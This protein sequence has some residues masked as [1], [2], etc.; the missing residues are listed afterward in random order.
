MKIEQYD[1]GSI[2]VD[3]KAYTAD[4]ILF[5]DRV[6]DGW[7]REQG[8]SLSLDDVDSVLGVSPEYLVIGTG[9]YGLMKIPPEVSRAIASKGIELCVSATVEACRKYN[10]LVSRG[11][12]VV[13]AFHLTC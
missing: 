10:E 13:G 3:G 9:R 5:P 6:Q 4:I 8:H 11:N 2:I 7:W 12:K 1:F